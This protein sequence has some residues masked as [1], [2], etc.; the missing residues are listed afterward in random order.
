MD[1]VHSLPVSILI[2]VSSVML[3]EYAFRCVL[4]CSLCLTIVFTYVQLFVPFA[5]EHGIE[6]RS[7]GR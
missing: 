4:V 3:C 1:V 5:Y 2:I 6:A 7:H